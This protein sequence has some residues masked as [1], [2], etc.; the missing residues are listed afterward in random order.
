MALAANGG[1]ASASS[2]YSSHYAVS[3]VN[4]GVRT[5]AGWAA[6]AGG[7]N[8]ATEHTYPDWVEIAF[9][10]PKTI[11][12]IDVFTLQDNHGAPVTETM[13]FAEH[14]I[15][16]FDVQYWNGSAWLNVPG[17]QIKGNNHVWRKLTFAG[18]NTTKIRVVVNKAL[19]GY[20]RIVEIEAYTSSVVPA[21]SATPTPAPTSSPTPT[22]TSG[23]PTAGEPF[24]ADSVE[25]TPPF[26]VTNGY[27]SQPR[28][29]SLADGGRVS[30]EFTVPDHGEYAVIFEVNAANWYS[31][32]LYLNVDAE[33]EDPVMTWDI[34]VTNG[35][36]NRIA[37]WRGGG[38][39]DN[40]QF[41]PKFF[42]LSPGKHELIIRGKE[43]NTE[44][45]TITI[46]KRPAPP[47]DL[48]VP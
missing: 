19:D 15:T 32:S 22:P 16:D 40:N 35:F 17:G 13:T 43:S 12:E 1:V 11:N 28:G 9:S 27:I 5:G 20:S 36:Q 29:T 23:I 30:Y 2:T 26:A 4:N 46:V 33:P 14:G 45:K 3:G 34:P 18:I 24:A 41:A 44:F 37:S 6:G 8:D 31:N 21:P 48:V 25:P 10:G 47:N 38:T 7:W 39:I 42:L